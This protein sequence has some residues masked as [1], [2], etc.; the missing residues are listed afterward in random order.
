VKCP[1]LAIFGEDDRFVPAN[2]TATRLRQY[3]S[4]VRNQDYEVLVVSGANHILTKTGSGLYGEFAPGYLD[5]MISWI[6]AHCPSTSGKRKA[7]K[8]P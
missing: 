8:L 5:R 3:L 2:L 7:N 1:V 4:E 6:H